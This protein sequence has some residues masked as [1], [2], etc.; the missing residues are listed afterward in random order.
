MLLANGCS[1]TEGY[2]LPTLED[3]WPYQL[4]AL[5]NTPVVNLAQGGASNQRIFRTTLEYLTTN[6]PKYLAIGWTDTSRYE[7]PVV[8]GT[9]ARVTN[10][11]V[12]FHEP[13][14]SNPDPKKL[15]EFYYKYLHNAYL[16]VDNLLT[17]I[18]TLQTVCQAKGIEYLFFNAFTDIEVAPILKDYHEYYQY[19]EHQLDY[20]LVDANLNLQTKLTQINQNH[21]MKP[22]MQYWC[23]KNNFE[24]D[25]AGH[26]LTAGHQ[27]WATEMFDNI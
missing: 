17:Y 13:L 24:F 7:L 10:S 11:D 23:R 25:S 4:G 15:H 14:T 5:V 22:T 9:Y 16:S 19:E 18:I 20:K 26:P 21:F 27:A 3:A 1:F 2:Y 6:T 12:L 8:N